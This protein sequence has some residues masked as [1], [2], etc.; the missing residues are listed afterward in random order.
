MI[1]LRQVGSAAGWALLGVVLGCGRPRERVT[2]STAA[3]TATPAP[4]V[5]AQEESV[6][7]YARGCLT[8]RDVAASD[9]V[10]VDGSLVYYLDEASGLWV[11]DASEP[12]HP[13]PRGH[14]GHVGSPLFLFVRDGVAWLG[15]V[16]WDRPGAG[17]STVIRAVDV[18]NS[19]APRVLGEV[20]RDGVVHDA[21]VIGGIFYL[22]RDEAGGAVVESLRVLGGALVT[23]DRSPLEGHPVQLAPSSP[24]LAAVTRREDKVGVH[25][26]DL[27]TTAIGTLELRGVAWLAGRIPIR[28]PEGARVAD[29]DDGR[30]VHVVT[31]ET[32]SCSAAQGSYLQIVDFDSGDARIGERAT[33]T[34]HG[35]FPVTRFADGRLYAAAAALGADTSDVWVARMY[36]SPAVVGRLPLSG[37]IATLS[38]R[39]ESVLAFGRR[40]TPSGV[41]L[42]VH[43][44]DVGA[45]GQ[46]RLRGTVAFGSDWT[47]SPADGTEAALSFDPASRLVA[48]PFTWYRAA[49]RRYDV[50]TQLVELGAAGPK[51]GARL[52][53]EGAADRAVFVGGH[54]LSIGPG[55]VRAVPVSASPRR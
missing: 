6:P 28:P 40:R 47:W 36:P 26:L 44:I 31:C 34:E 1:S 48:I 21:T 18:R 39:G 27:P 32:P 11:V 37:R 46:P 55:G 19:D 20:V 50:E 43:E 29:A 24:G 53:A 49:D 25:W 42:V 45:V 14:L 16:D 13:W 5:A 41:H 35:G 3:V 12:D 38:A 51:L 7:D 30:A 52:P 8:L 15:Y 2:T 4:A 17:A 9:V 10:R 33:L 23:V 22:L 54:L